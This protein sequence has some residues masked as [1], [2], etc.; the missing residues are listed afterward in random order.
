MPDSLVGLDLELEDLAQ[1]RGDR[2]QRR[3][4]VARRDRL[5]GA[6]E[7]LADELP[8]PVDVG[9]FLEDDRHHRDPELRDRAD[10]LDVGQAAHRPLDGKRQQRLDLQRRQRRGLG[11]HLDLH[12]RQVGH[13]VDRQVER[14]IDPQP[15]DQKRRHQHQ[16][17]VV[18]ATIR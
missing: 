4:A 1:R 2:A 10:L 12:V 17:A 15:G 7:P 18:A 9:P 16:E 3:R 6:G 13:G 8:R 14:R 5:G 11:D